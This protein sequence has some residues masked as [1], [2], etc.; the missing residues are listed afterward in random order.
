MRIDI[1]PDLKEEVRRQD[2]NR[3]V[4]YH[5]ESPPDIP[6]FPS[7]TSGLGGADFQ[8]LFQS[9]YDGAVISDLSGKILDAN[10]R[11]TNFL[12][13]PR[14]TLVTMNLTQLISGATQDTLATLQTGIEKDRFIL[15]QAYCIRIDNTLFPAEIAVNRLQIRGHEYLCCFIRDTSWRR[16]AEEMLRTVH[17][18]IQNAATGIAIA[19]LS[20]QIDYINRTG[21]QLWGYDNIAPILSMKLYDLIP[22]AEVISSIIDTVRKG[23]SWNSEVALAL[24]DNR[25]IHVQLSAS[26]NRDVDEQLIGMVISFLDISDR[27]RANEAEQQADRQ[28]VMVESLGAA[29]HHLGQPATILLSCIELLAQVWQTDAKT[30]AELLASG[31]EAAESLREKLHKLNDIAEYRTTTYMESPEGSRQPESRIIDVNTVPG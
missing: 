14:E 8:S 10:V 3:G 28:R 26:P 13:Y 7:S 15:I 17:N 1:P 12:H 20:G 21:A 19:D 6:D 2:R 4:L 9:V 16:Q 25:K 29:C 5:Q 22:D 23:S 11:L 30:T 18:A 31:K 24:P 27:I